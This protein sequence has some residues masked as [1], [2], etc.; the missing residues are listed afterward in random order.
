MWISSRWQQPPK[1]RAGFGGLKSARK[2][3][4][5]QRA[6]TVHSKRHCCKTAFNTVFIVQKS[7][8]VQLGRTDLV[9]L[10]FWT[11]SGAKH[12]K[13]LIKTAWALPIMEKDCRL[14][15]AIFEP[16]RTT[17]SLSERLC[18]LKL[19]LGTVHDVCSC[20]ALNSW[21]G[22]GAEIKI[23]TV[24]SGLHGSL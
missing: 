17:E 3:C 22:Q 18:F 13:T 19:G 21:F 15:F 4:R 16:E 10:M 9:W 7:K 20:F 11:Q 8:N 12:D 6:S 5:G 24:S 14:A 23:R 1:C 2:R